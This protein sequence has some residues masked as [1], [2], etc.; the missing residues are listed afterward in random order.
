MKKK[1]FSIIT[2]FMLCF[3]A[4]F[5]MTGCGE[6]DNKTPISEVEAMST[7]TAAME[8]M[9]S[10][11]IISM[12]GGLEGFMQINMIVT[13]SIVYTNT[14]MEI[15]GATSESWTRKEG[16]DWIQYDKSTFTYQEEGKEP[17]TTINYTKQTLTDFED[18]KD[19]VFEESVGEDFGEFVKAYIQDGE[20]VIVFDQLDEET[21]ETAKLTLTIKDGKLRKIQAGSGLVSIDFEIK[22]GE[23]ITETIPELPSPEGGWQ[24]AQEEPG[25]DPV[26]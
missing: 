5:M 2:C 8:A 26:V 22:Y 9:E 4:M 12:S 17:T 19:S 13:E 18:P 3:S 11:T 6:E 14:N 10:E 1:I 21:G 7:M 24:P 20:T 25:D 16:D 23:E 15:F